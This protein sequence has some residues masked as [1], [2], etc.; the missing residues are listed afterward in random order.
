MAPLRGEG[1]SAIV[2]VGQVLNMTL[3]TE[4]YG[5]TKEYGGKG[6]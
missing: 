5:V 6:A 2:P 1:V 3:S 4:H